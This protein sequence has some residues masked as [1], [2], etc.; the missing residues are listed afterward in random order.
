MRII[1]FLISLAILQSACITAWAQSVNKPNVVIIYADDVGY[2]D[3]SCDGATKI[4]TPN[5]DKIAA[6]GLRFT[7]AHASSSTCTPSRYSM[8]T[9]QYAWRKK[10]T[11]I[12][13]GDAPS[14]IDVSQTTI[15]SIMKDAGYETGVI[16][17]WHLGLGPQTGADWNG[18]IKPG[19]YE[20]GFNYSFIIPATPDRVPCVYVENGHVVNLDPKDPIEVSYKKRI[21]NEPVGSEHPELLKMMYSH[22]H[23]ET[24]V[25]SISR[26]GYMSGG[27]AAWW[28]D[29]L[30]ADVITAK[31]KKFLIENR[32]HPFF[33]YFAIQDVHVP[34][35]PNPRF[36]GKSG[37]GPR[38][39]ALLE[40]DY[41][42]GI[43][44]KTLDSLKLSKNTIVIF[45]SDNGPVLNDGYK[46]EAVEK[47]NGHTPGGP[48][49]GGK[50]SKL[51]AGTRMPMLIKW[52]GVIKPGTVS[53]AL[54]SQ[55]DFLASFAKLTGQKLKDNAAPDSYDMLNAL[56]GKSKTGR[57]SV[58]EQGNGLAIIK[59]D[60]KY[61]PPSTGPAIN[62][63]KNM[64]MGNSAEPQLYNL[65]NDIGEQNN[66]AAKYP[67]KVK[68]LAELLE[69]I[70]ANQ[71]ERLDFEKVYRKQSANRKEKLPPSSFKN[72]KTNQ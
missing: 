43:I 34:R 50:Y 32:A 30:M 35:V 39:D 48:M 14:I 13:A 23:D 66:L 18:L 8:L 64:E 41:N 36:A 25:D 40:L 54:V 27:K 59:G 20:L 9:G 58:V 44:L 11:G 68:E 6:Q 49:R 61:I 12:A 37:M 38:G 63:E 60:W 7:N 46:D 62:K 70:K 42:T 15:A 69:G 57:A 47:L 28:K 51:D 72:K 29:E 10:N 17:K 22:Q 5:I 71:N 2:G 31:G 53:N 24:I 45:S 1:K 19:P 21:G 16:G 56:L 65:K 4:K 52:P 3:I 33:L 67:A 26:I 55:V